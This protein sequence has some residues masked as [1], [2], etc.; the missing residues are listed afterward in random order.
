MQLATTPTRISDKNYITLG[1]IPS[2]MAELGINRG[3]SRASINRKIL[4]ETFDVKCIHSGHTRLW[5]PCDIISWWNSQEMF[6][7]RGK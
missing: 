7:P 3:F 6:S 5:R 2:L 4:N 1:E